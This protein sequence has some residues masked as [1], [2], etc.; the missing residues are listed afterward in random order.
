MPLSIHIISPSLLA[1]HTCKMETSFLSCASCLVG[2]RSL[3]ITLMATSQPSVRSFPESTQIHQCNTN[4]HCPFTKQILTHHTLTKQTFTCWQLLCVTCKDT[5]V[6]KSNEYNFDSI[7]RY[8]IAYTTWFIME[9]KS[10]I[11]AEVL[12]KTT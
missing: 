5:N 2:N 1:L 11:P 3:S 10:S 12:F 7:Q 9:S 4:K 8:K 6:T